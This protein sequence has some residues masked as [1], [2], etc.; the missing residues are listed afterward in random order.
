MRKKRKGLGM[1]E[2]GHRRIT[3]FFFGLLIIAFILVIVII[4]NNNQENTKEPDEV[5]LTDQEIYDKAILENNEA[6]CDQIADSIMKTFC[7]NLFAATEKSDDDKLIDKAIQENNKEYCN[8]IMDEAVKN[9][10]FNL[11]P[12]PKPAGGVDYQDLAIQNND[13]TYCNYL[14]GL[15]KEGCLNLFPK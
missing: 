4:V 2:L 6:Y 7:H 8:Q 10:C 13:P 5:P 14:E 12:K 15:E 9:A 11:F 3:G 1:S